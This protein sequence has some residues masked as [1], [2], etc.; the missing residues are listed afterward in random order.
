MEKNP[1]RLY[2]LLPY[3]YRLRDAEQSYELQALLRVISEQVNLVEA[4]IDQLYENWFIETCEDWLAPYIGD[5]VGYRMIN[6]AGEP[7]Q[8]HSKIDLERSRFLIPRRD[9][10]N[11][12]RYRRRKGALAWL[13]LLARDV[14]NWPARAVEFYRLLSGAQSINHL[15]MQRAHTADVRRGLEMEKAHGPF[16]SL[17][18][19]AGVRRINSPLPDRGR[20]NLPSVGIFVWRL[21]VYSV[22]RT[23][24]RCLEEI[25]PRCYAFS[26]L[27]NN[28]PLYNRPT[29]ETDPNQIAG[30]LNL[31]IPILRRPFEDRS[32]MP[33]RQFAIASA[34]YYGS[35]EDPKSLLIWAPNWPK[36]NAPQPIPRATV[37]PADLSEWQYQA[38]AGSVLVDPELGRMV[39]PQHQLPKDGVRVSY[40]Y[41]FSDDIGGGEYDRSLSQ[42]EGAQ[43]F[44][45]ETL[46]ELRA[47]LAPW[48]QA[49]QLDEQPEHAVIE[50]TRSGEYSV[51]INLQIQEGHSLQIRAA[52]RVRP[53]LRL[54]DVA[55]DLPDAFSV[56]GGPGSRLVLD[57]LLITGRGVRVYG[58]DMGQYEERTPPEDLCHLLIRHC[59]L[60]PG[61][62]LD[63]ECEPRR[64][65]EPSLELVN[66]GTQVTIEHSIIGSIYVV[67]DEVRTEPLKIR[68]SDSILDATDFDCD[69]P[70]C[71]GL[72]APGAGMN[73]WRMAHAVL[74]IARCTVFGRIY[75][76]AVELAENSIFMGALKV[77]RRQYGCV[78]FCYLS[79][80]GRTPRRFRCQPDLVEAAVQKLG[81]PQADEDRELNAERLRV[82]PQF[83]STRYGTPTYA[84]LAFTCAQEITRGAEDLSE[85]GV[86]HDLYQPQRADNLQRRLDEFTPAGMDAGIIFAS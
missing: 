8:A 21:K 15:R 55:V 36:K 23:Q 27:G 5:L 16:D 30:E 56:S 17:A 50:I 40:H 4:D 3:I 9:V 62:K 44:Q 77:A 25:N 18:H 2:D 6:E 26:V 14:A 10:A 41:A 61:W 68:M 13:E 43:V 72:A 1:D 54:G 33:P 46:Q 51:A 71:V 76:H 85:M 45:V 52:N 82:S 73:D 31:P 34:D 69:D 37:I 19:L 7:G 83:N 84:Q 42:P 64:P 70:G 65:N 63:V 57:G 12:I 39:F 79:P 29:P 11:T 32:E 47:A 35:Q 22:T 49:D 60:V 38:P 58:P 48:Q 53:V 75:T 80:G 86:F 81:L 28:S 66:T 59:T 20:Y 67:A 74:T 78:R 24:A